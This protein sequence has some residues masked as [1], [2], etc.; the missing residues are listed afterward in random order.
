[1]EDFGYVEQANNVAIFVANWLGIES[2][3]S[4]NKHESSAPDV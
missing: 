2:G 4:V 1:M 3:N